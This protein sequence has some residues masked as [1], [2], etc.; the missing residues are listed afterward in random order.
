M[1]LPR[2][3][4]R[5]HAEVAKEDAHILRYH[6]FTLTAP[7]DPT[8]EEASVVV[9]GEDGAERA[10]TPTELAAMLVG[11]LAGYQL[12][13]G[14]DAVRRK[15]AFAMPKAFPEAHARALLDAAAVAGLAAEDV[16]VTTATDAL[17]ATYRQKHPAGDFAEGERRR[18]LLVDVGYAQAAA[19]CFEI[20]AEGFPTV[21]GE[22]FDGGL[23]ASNFDAKLFDHFA[24]EVANKYGAEEGTVQPGAWCGPFWGGGVVGRCIGPVQSNPIP[25]SQQ[26]QSHH[27]GSKKAL[28]LLAGVEKIKKLLSTI[29][30]AQTQ[31][32]NVVEGR[33]IDLHLTRE[34]F[35]ALVEPEVTRFKALVAQALAAAGVEEGALAAVEITGGAMRMPCLQEAVVAAAGFAGKPLG[36]KLDDNAV[37]YGAALLLAGGPAGALV[38]NGNENGGAENEAAAATG[39]SLLLRGEAG[40]NLGAEERA[41]LAAAEAARVARDGELHALAEVKNSMESFVLE[42]RGMAGHAKFGKLVDQGQV[43]AFADGLEEWLYSEEAD[44]ASLAGA[45]WVGGWVCGRERG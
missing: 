44:A 19:V 42:L 6:M 36:L 40:G 37:A 21:L 13:E 27:A 4:G 17:L 18:V 9:Q 1:H 5:P 10:Y 14:E 43:A 12:V 3:L 33:D 31:V 11:T 28:R 45:C 22:A 16:M 2:L 8:V 25:A 7:A 26:N 23:G 30:A 39:P 35:Y 29:P 24:G 15:F 20:G 38:A 34:A 41:A 32:E